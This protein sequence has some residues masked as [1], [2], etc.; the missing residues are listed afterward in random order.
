MEEAHVGNPTRRRS[1]R[2]AIHLTIGF[3][4]C[5]VV[6]A[7]ILLHEALV[8]KLASA[9]DDATLSALAGAAV[10][11]LHPSDPNLEEAAATLRQ[12]CGRLLRDPPV[13][14]VEVLDREGRSLAS[15]AISD[16][17]LPLLG[18]SPGAEATP[19]CSTLDLPPLYG[20]YHSVR[21]ARRVEAGFPKAESGAAPARLVLLVAS[22]PLWPRNV[23]MRVLYWLPMAGIGLGA[24]LLCASH[25]RRQVIRPIMLLVD[26]VS[27]ACSDKAALP[28]GTDEVDTIARLVGRLQ[29]EVDSW[30][31]RAERTERRLDL[32]V[33]TETQRIAR[34]LRKVQQDAWRDPLTGINNR[35]IL[36][37]KFSDI[38]EAQR[39]AR[40]DLAAVMFDVD[41]FK[42]LNDTQGHKAGDAVLAFAGQLFRQCLRPDDIAVRYGGDEFL[43]ILPGLSAVAAKALADRLLALFA[44]RVRVMVDL[45]PSPTMSAGVAS[46]LNNRPAGPQ[47]LLEMADRALYASKQAGKATATVLP[48]G[49]IP[50]DA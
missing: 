26:A 10:A 45:R 21:Q 20:R 7:G 24:Y 18:K 13:L 29:E 17:L 44:Q 30:R 49:V 47:D 28:R 40:Q 4:I 31:E 22:G 15:A 43:L 5:S 48:A 42:T 33:A 36:D 38:F 11:A 19:A 14:A 39:N 41:H 1:L 9:S 3:A 25:L 12:R 34:D 8:G 50:A 27:A 35:R 16:S 46:L 37:E 32:R 2:Q 23:Q 6:T